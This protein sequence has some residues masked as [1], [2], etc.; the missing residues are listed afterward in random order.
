MMHPSTPAPRRNIEIKARCASL[1]AA[2]A[3][4]VQIGA[5]HAGLLEQ[6]DTYFVT[7]YGRLKLREIRSADGER[8]ELIAYSRPN[9][10]VA[11]SSEYHLAAVPDAAATK[12]ALAMALGVRGEVR[13][14]R[15]LYL[16]HNVRIH[17]DDVEGL[18]AFLEFEA[19]ISPSD[20]EAVSRERLAALCR[21]LN[22]R[23]EDQIAKSYSD[24]LNL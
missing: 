10:A 18:G 8:A 17:L 6:V 23:D 7:P 2:R 3:A 22:V 9:E 4:S 13:K 1:E 21:A 11:R 15:D 19:V 16:W 14:R 12:A 5:R 24:L 20:G